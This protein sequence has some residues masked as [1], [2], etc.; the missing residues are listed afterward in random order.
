MELCRYLRWNSFTGPLPTELGTMDALTH[1]CVRRPYPQRLDARV[2][3]GFW[4]HQTDSGDGGRAGREQI[5]CDGV[6][7][8]C[9]DRLGD[10]HHRVNILSG[11]GGD[12]TQ[13]HQ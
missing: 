8:D 5:C 13:L 7:F 10:G 11:V 6:D 9:T 12:G 2:V 4:A 3:I 1:L